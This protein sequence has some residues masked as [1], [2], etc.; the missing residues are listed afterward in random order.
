M[1]KHSQP[2]LSEDSNC[3]GS[4]HKLMHVQDN[5][6]IQTNARSSLQY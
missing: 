4:R 1:V 5:K 2:E 3:E 6:Q